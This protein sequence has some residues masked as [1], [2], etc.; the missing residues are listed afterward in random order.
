MADSEWFDPW[1]KR[2]ALVPDGVPVITLGSKLLPVRQGDVPAM[3]K[4]AMDDEEKYA[5]QLKVADLAAA[6]LNARHA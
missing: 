3:L 6:A 4:I 1:L 2:W 5:G